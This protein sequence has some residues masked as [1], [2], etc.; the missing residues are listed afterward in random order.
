[1]T[2]VETAKM[3]ERGQIIIPKEIRDYIDAGESTIFTVMPIDRETIIMKKLDRQRII[4][5]LENIRNKIK[6][7]MTSEEINEEITEV[8]RLRRQRQKR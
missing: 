7:K 8:R 1:M 6:D 3:S 2:E 4:R 5:E